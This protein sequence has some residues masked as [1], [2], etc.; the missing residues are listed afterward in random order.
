[1]AHP[2]LRKQ[3]K[4]VVYVCGVSSSLFPTHTH[5]HTCTHTPSQSFIIH[6]LA[7]PRLNSFVFLVTLGKPDPFPVFPISL[8]FLP[9]SF[10]P[11][12]IILKIIPGYQTRSFLIFL[13]ISLLPTKRALSETCAHFTERSQPFFRT[14]AFDTNTRFSS[15]GRRRPPFSTIPFPSFVDE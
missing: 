6:L 7:D 8:F 1:M 14:I 15:C 3:K 10:I 4:R 2:Q 11:F 13:V 12:S 5:A 9:S